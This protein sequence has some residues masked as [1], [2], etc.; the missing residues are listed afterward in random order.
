MQLLPLISLHRSVETHHRQLEL[1]FGIGAP[2]FY[3]HITHGMAVI[4][5]K[6]ESIN[7]LRSTQQSQ[8][9]M[10][11]DSAEDVGKTQLRGSYLM[12]GQVPIDIIK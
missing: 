10:Y 1:L 9:V 8:A 11:G 6:E 4:T 2:A 3:I 5:V 12:A 7:D